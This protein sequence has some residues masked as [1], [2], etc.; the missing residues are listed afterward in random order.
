MRAL[1]GVRRAVM[2]RKDAPVAHIEDGGDEQ[3]AFLRQRVLHALGLLV[4]LGALDD[5]I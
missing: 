4:V 2:I 5:V 3:A 1:D